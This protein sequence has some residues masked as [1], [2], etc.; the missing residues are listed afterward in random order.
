[1]IIHNRHFSDHL[2]LEMSD[3]CATAE[4]DYQAVDG[5]QTRRTAAMSAVTVNKLK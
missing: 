4:I 3:L 2:I 5:A 1:M